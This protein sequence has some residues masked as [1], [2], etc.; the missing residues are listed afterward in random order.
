MKLL[1]LVL[2]CAVTA[3]ISLACNDTVTTTNS[4][5]PSRTASSPAASSP[6]APADEFANARGHYSKLCEG[7][8]GPNGEGGPVKTA[9]G[10]QI[11]VPSLKAPH[12]VRHTDEEL[13]KTITNG[14]EEMPSFK[15]KMGPELI[16]EMVRF[17]RKNFQGK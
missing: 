3:L 13:V 12:A 17:V 6:A 1:A 11:K 9:E 7:C 8:H 15:D 10:K 16:T 14:E 5:T 4:T 2:T